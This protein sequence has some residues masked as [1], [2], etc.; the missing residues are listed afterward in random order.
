M[1]LSEID[2]AEVLATDEM[3]D[4]V[5]PTLRDCRSFDDYPVSPEQFAALEQ[6]IGLPL[7]GVA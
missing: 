7:G 1:A 4:R 3:I 2:L 5:G 6:A